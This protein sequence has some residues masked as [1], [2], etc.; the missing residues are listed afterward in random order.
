MRTTEGLVILLVIWFLELG[1]FIA[2]AELILAVGDGIMGG[3]TLFSVGGFFIA[4]FVAINQVAHFNTAETR[5]KAIIFYGMWS[6]LYL[7]IAYLSHI[8][9][10]SVKG[11]AIALDSVL[12][13]LL[14]YF[15]KQ[16]SL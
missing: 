2:T 3:L 1:M 4:F 6:G 7:L 9:L 5:Q 8:P 14:M 15:L 13:V 10:L 16:V 12:F 11:T